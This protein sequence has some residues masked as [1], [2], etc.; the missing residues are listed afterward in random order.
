MT[1][2]GSRLLLLASPGASSILRRVA[3]R[4]RRRC[5]LGLVSAMVYLLRQDK[6]LYDKLS[7]HHKLKLDARL[8]NVS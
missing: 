7:P 2:L 3:S 4:R 8:N 5:E 1:T 6:T